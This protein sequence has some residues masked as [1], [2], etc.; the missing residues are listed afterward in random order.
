VDGGN[1]TGF[2]ESGNFGYYETVM[3]EKLLVTAA[4]GKIAF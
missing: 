1:P 3:F 4:V 2:G